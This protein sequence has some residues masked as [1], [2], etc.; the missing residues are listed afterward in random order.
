MTWSTATR[1]RSSRKGPTSSIHTEYAIGA[2]YIHKDFFAPSGYKV[3]YLVKQ[4]VSRQ[5][6]EVESSNSTPTIVYPALD[7]YWLIE[8]TSDGVDAEAFK[9][10]VV[11]ES[12]SEDQEEA[13]YTVIGRGRV[14]SKG[15]LLGSSGTLD[16]RIRATGGV[17]PRARVL[18]MKKIQKAD[19]P[20]WLRNPFGDIFKVNVS[21]IG[22]TRVAGVGLAE[23]VDLSI[24]YSEVV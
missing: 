11:G 16:A 18:R 8:P 6:Q 5:G 1:S 19:S 14:V 24:P 7:G 4:A 21:S 17:S 13:S 12:F 2:A 23:F 22:F 3:N 10:S 9:I 15:D 20:L